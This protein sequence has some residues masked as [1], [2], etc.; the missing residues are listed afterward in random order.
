MMEPREA[1]T[2]AYQQLEMMFD[3]PTFETWLRKATF[4]DFADGKYTIGVKNS[5]A[6]D[7]LQHRLYRN[8]RRVVSDVLGA[9]IEIQFEIY[10]DPEPVYPL[11]PQE[12]EEMPLL[13]LLAQKQQATPRDEAQA[14]TSYVEV[15]APVRP[16]ETPETELNTK[17]TFERFIVNKA[18]LL[19]YEAARAVA[20]HPATVYNPLLI[21]G[22]V[23]L[24]KTHLIQAIAHDCRQRG[25][26]ANYISS[27]AF[28]NDLIQS[29][30]TRTT[31]MFRE[32]YRQI[33]VLIVDDIQF[34]IG[35]DATQEEFFHTFN[36]LGQFNKQIVLA[37]DRPPHEM[38]ALAERLRSRFQGGLV[39]DVQPPEYETRLAILKMWTREQNLTLQEEALARIA[40]DAPASVRDMLGMFNRIAAQ[41]RLKQG[42]LSLA[43]VEQELHRYQRPRQQLTLEEIIERVAVQ[44]NL[45]WA[46]LTGKKR[47][48]KVNEARQIA[49]FLCRE[50]TEMSLPQIAAEFGGRSHSTILHGIQK[51]TEELQTDAHFKKRLEQIKLQVVTGRA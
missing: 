46:D 7:M 26:R 48:Q 16:P 1:W 21:Y 39:A 23:G 36:M 8:I 51:M 41:S 13:K 2:A 32:R 24:G 43:G 5:Y 25:F 49:M 47:T 15:V 34:I 6:R 37:S 3:R 31:A 50:L 14:L 27:E 44:C 38:P 19:A 11:V 18:S 4:L 17:Y 29:I 30:R 33:D 12:E 45:T 10:K 9:P 42:S 35:K 22:G 20:E 28:T 40:Q